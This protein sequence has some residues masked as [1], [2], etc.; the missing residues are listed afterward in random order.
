[1]STIWVFGCSFSSGHAG[2]DQEKTYGNLLAKDLNYNIKNLSSPGASN[3]ILFHRLNQN[4]SNFQNGDIILYQFTG[5]NRIG[6]FNDQ[7]DESYFSTAGLY[8]LG[9]STKK[10]EPPYDN[11]SEENLESLIDYILNWQTKR[12]KFLHDDPLN[13][14]EFIS[15]I[16]NIKIVTLYLFDEVDKKDKYVTY[17]PTDNKPKNISM[18]EY[19]M[20]NKLTVYDDDPVRYL[21][22]SHP[23]SLGHFKLKELIKEKI[24]E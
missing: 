8:E 7:K 20:T 16:K 22:D 6:F 10:K 13:V 14:L 17:L 5:F 12:K 15:K 4:L 18:N 9:I 11:I 1:M 24:N 19:F 3:D 23:N 2:V 21:G